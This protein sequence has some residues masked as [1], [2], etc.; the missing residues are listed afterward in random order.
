MR[1]RPRLHSNILS[2]PIL[3]TLAPALLLPVSAFGQR[4]PSDTAAPQTATLEGTVRTDDGKVIPFGVTVNLAT[5]EGMVTAQQP[6][7]SDGRFEFDNLRKTTYTISVTAQGFQTAEKT[8]N[9]GYAANIYFANFTLT[10]AGTSKVRTPPPALSDLQAPKKARREYEKGS[11]ALAE[12]HFADARSHLEKAVALDPCY[13]R[14][15]TDL[16]TVLSTQHDL[17]GAEATL[18]QAIS[19]DAGFLDAYV[20]LGEILNAQKRFAEG[21]TV[22]EEGLRRAPGSWPFYYQL[23]VARFGLAKYHDAE[24]EFL[25]AESFETS[26]PADIHVKLAD[27]Y[28]KE[29]AYDKAYG[30]MQAYLRADPNGRFAARIKGVMHQMED[31]GALHTRQAQAD[32]S[33]RSANKP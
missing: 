6:V 11:R 20:E 12:R 7:H 32:S 23:G 14:A 17:K 33:A 18:R 22:L 19:C 31:S 24:Q 1:V 29:D 25:K 8:L 2:L 30:E 5:E 16:A 26:P 3:V 4:T 13:A 10:P 15:R 21:E 9:V 27:V 28:L